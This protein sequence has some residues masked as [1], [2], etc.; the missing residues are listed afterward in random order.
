M[1]KPVININVGSIKSQLVFDESLYSDM[2]QQCMFAIDN[3]IAFFAP[4]YQQNTAYQ[5]GHWDGKIHLFNPYPHNKFGHRAF[6]FYTGKIKQVL[7]TIYKFGYEA[8]LQDTRTAHKLTRKQWTWNPKFG[9][10]KYQEIATEKAAKRSIGLIKLPTGSGKTIVA[11]SIIHKLGI[12]PFVMFV[13]QKDLLYQAEE[14]FKDVFGMKIGKIG[15]GH[16]DIQ[17]I[18]VCTIQTCIKAFHKED[19]FVEQYKK[20]RNYTDEKTMDE[21]DVSEDKY[22]QIRALIKSCN[23][24]IFDEVHHA[25]SDTC[26]MVLELCENAAHRYGIGAT[27]KRD[28]GMDAMIEALFGDVIYDISASELIKEGYLT[29]PQIIMIPISNYLGECDSYATEYKTYVTDNEHRNS[30]IAN[31]ANKAKE[32]GMPTLVLVKHISHGKLLKSLIPDSEFIQGAL[33]AAKRKSL[34]NKMRSGEVLCTIATTLA[35]EGLDIPCLECLILGGSGK[36]M[37]KTMQRVGRVLRPDPQNKGK[38]AI[39]YDFKDRP[40]ILRRHANAR[41]KMYLSE[42]EFELYD[43]E[44]YKTPPKTKDLM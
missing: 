35:D 24:V 41:K 22:E 11:A 3:K 38:K 40:K 18:T 34:I 2:F 28:D 1:R 5:K 44:N 19:E 16:C 37:V 7:E 26:R 31:L 42:P 21:E 43:L 6:E 29:K 20:F 15:D 39:V 14:R 36:S 27:I 13:T 23:G 9:K 10:R 32:S 33:S 8:K 17:D 12:S 4:D 25:S 30:I